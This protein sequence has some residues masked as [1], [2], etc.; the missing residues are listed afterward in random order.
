MISRKL[1]I[2]FM[3]LIFTIVAMAYSITGNRA[4]EIVGVFLFILFIVHNILNRRWYKAILKG[5]YNV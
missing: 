3:M 2:D 5:K 4:H 1:V